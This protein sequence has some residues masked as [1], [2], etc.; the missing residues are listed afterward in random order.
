MLECASEGGAKDGVLEPLRVGGDGESRGQLCADPERTTSE[1]GRLTCP[2]RGEE[3]VTEK[4]VGARAHRPV[5]AHERHVERSQV[6][7][8]GAQVAVEPCHGGAPRRA[9]PPQRA[10]AAPSPRPAS[11]GARR[12]GGSAWRPRGRRRLTLTS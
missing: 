6:A 9:P 4:L 12:T 10:P 1:L 8:H 11:R 7:S 3:G 5:H 2:A